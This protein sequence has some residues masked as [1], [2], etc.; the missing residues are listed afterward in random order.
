MPGVGILGQKSKVPFAAILINS[1][2]I[3]LIAFE[4]RA[5]RA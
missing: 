1:L 5:D 4:A 2:G 3:T